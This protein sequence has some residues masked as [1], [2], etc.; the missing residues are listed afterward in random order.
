MRPGPEKTEIAAPEWPGGGLAL[1][2]DAAKAQ[3]EAT[4]QACEAPSDES[5]ASSYA[6]GA[7]SHDAFALSHEYDGTKVACDGAPGNTFVAS[8]GNG[9][10]PHGRMYTR[11]MARISRPG[12]RAKPTKEQILDALRRL[13]DASPDGR[14]S[15]PV[16]KRETGWTRYWI[17]QFWPESGWRGACDEAGV[18]PGLQ[19]AVDTDTRVS[20]DE[21]AMRFA[22][23]VKRLKGKIPPAYR[24]R[25][26]TR[27]GPETF[28]RGQTYDEAKVRLIRT[29]LG[30]PAH[31]RKT[32]EIE[33]TLQSE[34]QRLTDGA[35]LTPVALGAASSPRRNGPIAVPEQYRREV[36][37][38]RGRGEEEQR[39]LVGRL[40]VDVLGYRRSRILS[41]HEWN[42]V[43][44]SDRKGNP[45][46]VVEVKGALATDSEKRAA[47]RQGFDYAHERGMRY[48]VISDGD[49]YEIY[50]RGTGGRLRYQEMRVGN[51][52][53]TALTM[54]DQD[55]LGLLAA[56]A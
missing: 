48:V 1:V 16:F 2:H 46:L 25:A 22:G 19:V 42:D 51:F 41:E 3:S 37:E 32:P 35:S 14:V 17:D 49:Y 31:Q 34:L 10:A 4:K 15:L 40:F 44:V 6:S 27:T 54:R 55:L 7:P 28:Q 30:L 9:G 56:E 23:A 20:D 13:R 11:S 24:L 38:L 50:D 21:L 12:P 26:L 29:Y 47:R 43:R 45:W 36:E 39:Q 52:H 5:F 18:Q 8:Q 53:L 33:G